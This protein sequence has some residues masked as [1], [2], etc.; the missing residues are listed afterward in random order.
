MNNAEVI[1]NES[2]HMF[3]YITYHYS[4]NEMKDKMIYMYLGMTPL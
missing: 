2:N 1:S 4:T 3:K